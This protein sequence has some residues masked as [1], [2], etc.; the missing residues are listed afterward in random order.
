MQDLPTWV[1][2]A[3]LAQIRIEA[4]NLFSSR[5]PSAS[6][7]FFS[8]TRPVRQIIGFQPIHIVWI[9]AA[10]GVLWFVF[11]PELSMRS[12]LGRGAMVLFWATRLG[13]ERLYYDTGCGRPYRLTDGLLSLGFI[14]VTFCFG[15]IGV[16]IL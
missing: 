13:I 1:R 3:D 6:E 9:V 7:E 2:L 5:R 11:G 12:A 15:R 8:G 10:L 16:G 14:L 4:V